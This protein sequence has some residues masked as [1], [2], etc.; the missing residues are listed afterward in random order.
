M[1]VNATLSYNGAEA[2]VLE[3]FTLN[4]ENCTDFANLH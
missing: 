3:N 2:T 4:F 1:F